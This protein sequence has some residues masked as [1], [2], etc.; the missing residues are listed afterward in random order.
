MQNYKK[1]VITARRGGKGKKSED[2]RKR[3]K[4]LS[5][6]MPFLSSDTGKS[7]SDAID[8]KD[9]DAFKKLWQSNVT[10]KLIKKLEEEFKNDKSKSD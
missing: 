7:L 9:L 5:T 4:F 6:V 8:R 3:S 1:F 2:S 10:E